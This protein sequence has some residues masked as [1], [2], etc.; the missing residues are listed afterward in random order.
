MLLPKLASPATSLYD[1][2]G[3]FPIHVFSPTTRHLLFPM[4]IRRAI[5]K[6]SSRKAVDFEGD[7]PR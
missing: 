2:L 4:D 1:I 7:A 6:L 5:W 3:Q